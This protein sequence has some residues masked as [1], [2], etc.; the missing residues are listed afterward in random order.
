MK[1]YEELSSEYDAMTQFEARFDKEKS[2]FEDLVK[3]Y[4]LRKVLDAGCGTGFHSIL[5][6]KLGLEVTGFDSSSEMV[7]RA[8]ENSRAHNVH[9]TFHQSTFQ[10][11]S[12]CMDEQ[13]D[14]VIC[15]G[16]SLP[17]LLTEGE[18]VLSL[19][20]F[21][22]LLSEGGILVIQYLNYDRIMKSKER[23]VDVK[24]RE[25]NIF[26][27]FYDFGEKYIKFNILMVKENQNGFSHK[28]ISTD[29]RPLYHNELLEWL[30]RVGF[31]NVETWGSFGKEG[32]FKDRSKDLILFAEKISLDNSQE[33]D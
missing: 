6:A 19:T 1:F 29:L 20:N 24:K 17:H 7:K 32:F 26:V 31:Q 14:A 3:E 12:L 23:I 8:T 21:F 25:G 4:S 11:V 22:N 10:D 30:R 16:N 2:F 18:V 9:I 28:L 13:F 5:L 15:M 27:R 33:N